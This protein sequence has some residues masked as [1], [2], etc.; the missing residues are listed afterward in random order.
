MIISLS[1]W[2]G[3]ENDQA[4]QVAIGHAARDILGTLFLHFPEAHYR[5]GD[6][7]NGF[8]AWIRALW[9]GQQEWHE[10][11]LQRS[12]PYGRRDLEI[13]TAEWGELGPAAGPIRNGHMLDGDKTAD[14]KHGTA[15]LLI[16][17]PKP[18]LRMP[19]SG[20]WSCVDAAVKRS[21]PVHIC[22]L[23]PKP[24]RTRLPIVAGT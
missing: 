15:H 8:D 16:A 20:T 2:R 3:P 13:F 14:P 19:R 12:E 7:P 5:I 21:I 1:G 18:G 6:C 23:F 9:D 10:P 24:G 22:P 17:L 4:N 11:L